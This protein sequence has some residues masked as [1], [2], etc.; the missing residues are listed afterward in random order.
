MTRFALFAALVLLSAPA[1]AQPPGPPGLGG[2][3]IID[4]KADKGKLA[5]TEYVAVPVQKEVER[6]VVANGKQ[7][8]VKQTVTVHEVVPVTKA[9]ELKGLKV[10][11]AA[12]KEID[13][14]KVAERLKEATPVVLASGALPAKHRALFKDTTLF[15]EPLP[16]PAPK[17]PAGAGA[18]PALPP[19]PPAPPKG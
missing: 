13:A 19:E 7:V 15:V 11:D 5:W 8:T 17:G 4:A 2:I 18:A 14:D 6:V 12:G 3:T 16:P 10:T 9:V 1:L